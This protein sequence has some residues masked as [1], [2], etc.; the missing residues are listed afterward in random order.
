MAY[1]LPHLLTESTQRFPEREAIRFKGEGLTYTELDEVTNQVAR[2]LQSVGVKRGDRV[3]V[4]VHKS[5]ATV[6]AVFGIMK[7]GGVYVPL[8]PGAPAKRHAYITRNCDIKA[9]VTATNKLKVLAEFYDEGTPIES[10]VMTD[11]KDHDPVELPENVQVISWD[12]VKATDSSPIADPGTI[13][14]DLAYILYTS[15]ST[16]TPK[17]RHDF[18]PHDFHIC[19]LVC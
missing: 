6:I 9:V 13:E 5:L 8:D 17:G 11:N 12:D 15:G 10:V 19:E 18:A 2:S 1:L 3:G 14:A 4:Y 7:A 16:G